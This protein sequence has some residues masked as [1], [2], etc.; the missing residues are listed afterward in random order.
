MISVGSAIPAAAADGVYVALGDSY[1]AGVGTD[2]EQNN[3]YRSQYGYPALIADQQGLTLDHQACN[4]ATVADVTANQLS[5]LDADTAWVS[6][7]IGGND[8]GFADVLVEC[9]LPGWA[10]D[11]DGAIDDGLDVI[12]NELPDRY[13]TLFTR[14]AGAAPEARVAVGGYPL[15]FNGEDCNLATFFSPE[16]ED[17]LN[18]ATRTL[19]ELIAEQTAGHDFRYVD[20]EPSFDDHAVCDDEEWINGLSD[21]V[22]DSYHPNRSGHAA[23]A[24][25]FSSA[26]T[27]TPYATAPERRAA[28]TRPVSVRDQADAVLAMQLDSSDRLAAAE[29]NGIAAER[30]VRLT[31]RLRSP[32]P[33]TVRSA[34]RSLQGLDRRAA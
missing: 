34:L 19:N 20:A 29:R 32:D 14:I 15:I 30:I 25:I 5:A 10:S 28:A 24:S 21:P 7:T 33:E 26:L 2:D 1:S 13:D 16:E 3:C 4:G 6:M 23:Y 18:A 9:A 17:R 8:A 27:G 11:C 22:V 12:A 31:D